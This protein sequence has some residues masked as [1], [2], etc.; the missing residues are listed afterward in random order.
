MKQKTIATRHLRTKIAAGYV[1]I[2]FVIFGI[3]YIWLNEQNRQQELEIT[4]Q[5][6]RCLRKD[7]HEVYV[8]MVDLSLIG[9]T[10]LDWNEEDMNIYHKKRLEVDSLLSL[11]KSSYRSERIDS[12]CR[13]LAEKE[14]LLNKIMLVL[15]EQEEIKDKIARR[16]PVIARKSSQEEP[17][18]RKRTGFLGLFGKKEEAKPTVTT[19]MLNTLN[20]DVIA[21]VETDFE[22]G[23]PLFYRTSG[24]GSITFSAESAAGVELVTTPATDSFMEGTMSVAT[25]TAGYF[26]KNGNIYPIA[27]GDKV[28]V[29]PFRAYVKGQ[30]DASQASVMSVNVARP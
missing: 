24:T 22:A 7:I 10:V 20:S 15:N 9:E 5:K 1:L 4:S 18:K 26:L 3:V 25:P 8:K 19:S 6:I 23:K 30:N 11:F 16:V 29:K 21:L 13:L 27:N 12:V 17:P 14:N 2:L 28:K